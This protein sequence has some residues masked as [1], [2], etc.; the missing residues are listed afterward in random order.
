MALHV[1]ASLLVLQLGR[2][3]MGRRPAAVAAVLF[4]VHPVH[5]EAVAGL[6]GRADL[7]CAVFFL[8]GVLD[9]VRYVDWRELHR[10]THTNVPGVRGQFGGSGV[11]SVF[12]CTSEISKQN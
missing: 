9:Y 6:V 10:C 7:L 11:E 5:C 3:L 4:A 8:R 12:R 1:V 2:R